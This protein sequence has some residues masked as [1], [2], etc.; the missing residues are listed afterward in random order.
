[1][2]LR[3]SFDLDYDF[4]HDPDSGFDL[5]T[6]SDFDGDADGDADGDYGY[7]SDFDSSFGGVSSDAGFGTGRV[8]SDAAVE[9]S[10]PMT[11]RDL[12]KLYESSLRDT[13]AFLDARRGAPT[14]ISIPDVAVSLA[15]VAGGAAAAAYLAQRFRTAG[16]VVPVGLTLGALGLL[17]AYFGAFGG[18]TN[19]ALRISLGL[20]GGAGA[21]WAAGV[22]AVH[23][24]AAHAPRTAGALP[25]APP[26][27]LPAAPPPVQQ[28]MQQPMMMA[29]QYA[30]T[31]QAM[32]LQG[33]AYGAPYVPA[34]I[35]R[36]A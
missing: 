11:R 35:R 32:P 15:E 24:E 30:P 9:A 6:S 7:G 12:D 13:A 3:S 33:G 2:D 34:F 14:R 23:G 5:D 19:H 17:G 8:R 22:G 18:A 36:A 26:A 10:M 28:P 20:A 25:G 1:M 16:A 27:A 31:L 4:D 29:Q 21:L